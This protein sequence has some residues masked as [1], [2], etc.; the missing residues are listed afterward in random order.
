MPEGQVGVFL[1][2]LYHFMCMQQQG[3]TSM[4]DA[5]AGV[6]VHLRVHSWVAQASLTRLFAQVILGLGSLSG[7]STTNTNAS[8]GTQ[9]PQLAVP[10]E[11]VQY[12]AIP[13][14]GSTMVLTSLFPG[15]QVRSDGSAT[16][17]IY[18][19]NDTDS[20][21]SCLDHSTPVKAPGGK[22]QLLASTPKPKPKLLVTTQQHRNKLA[23]M[24][25]G[26]LHG[27]HVWPLQHRASGAHPW[28]TDLFGWKPTVN[29]R[30]SRN[31]SF[32]SV[33]EHAKFTTATLT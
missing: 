24:L 4:M 23:V 30:T 7:L 16:Q 18:L 12:V 6:P 1:A 15:K 25:Q 21:I 32:V 27:T 26:A 22:C 3:I 5:Q 11:Q 20:R 8:I 31:S 2:A 13:L 17:P 28:A 33:E 29:P 19:G 14:D 9:M 10:T